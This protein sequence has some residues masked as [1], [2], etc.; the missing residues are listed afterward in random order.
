MLLR[1]PCPI[2][3]RKWLASGSL[4]QLQ[5]FL[6]RRAQCGRPCAY[7]ISLRALDAFHVVVSLRLSFASMRTQRLSGSVCGAVIV[8]VIVYVCVCGK[9]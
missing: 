4:I 6:P 3:R 1:S 2:L 9:R 5:K 7:W 8:I